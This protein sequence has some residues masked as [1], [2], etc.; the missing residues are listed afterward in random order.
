MTAAIERCW[1]NRFHPSEPQCDGEGRWKKPNALS[2]FARATRWCDKHKHD[3]DVPSERAAAK[4]EEQP[5]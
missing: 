1:F 2:D 5:R 4:R 3:D